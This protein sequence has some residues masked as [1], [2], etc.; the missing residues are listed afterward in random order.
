MFHG[1]LTV[2]PGLR[3]AGLA[4]V[5]CVDGLPFKTWRCE[6]ISDSVPPWLPAVTLTCVTLLSRPNTA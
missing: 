4:A 5:A 3:R 2:D 6:S 1:H